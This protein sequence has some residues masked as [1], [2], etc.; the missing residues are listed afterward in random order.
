MARK[1]RGQAVKTEASEKRDRDALQLRVTGATYQQISDVLGYGS[2]ANAYRAVK[3][4][5]DETRE[6]GVEQ[7]RELGKARYETVIQRM[8]PVL[9]ETRK[10]TE[11]TEQGVIERNVPV[12]SVKERVAAGSTIINAQNSLN[13]LFGLNEETPVV[14]ARTQTLVVEA[15]TL[16]NNMRRAFEVETVSDVEGDIVD[17]V[18]EDE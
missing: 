6:E 18:V 12:H 7:L 8:M 16:T 3:R 17:V 10:E 2:R 9:T 4:M 15:Q 13:R 1:A 5:L 11:I 14:D